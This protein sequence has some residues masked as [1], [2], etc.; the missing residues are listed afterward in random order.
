MAKFCIFCGTQL[1]DNAVFC[2][3]CGKRV[4]PETTPEG[5][6]VI[7]APP[8]AVVTISDEP[9]AIREEPNAAPRQ[10]KKAAPAPAAEENEQI[11]PLVIPAPPGAAV[12]ISDE[13]PVMPDGPKAAPKRR[14]KAA[15]VPA[16]EE[17][18]Q[19]EP[20]VIPAP[21][22]A[23]VTI[24]DE[25]PKALQKP[26]PASRRKEKSSSSTKSKN[27]GCFVNLILIFVMVAEL[28]VA[29]FKYPGFLKTEEKDRV[30]YMKTPVPTRIVN[31]ASTAVPAIT[32][33]DDMDPVY[34]P[35]QIA[36]APTIS[37]PVSGDN[38][39]AEAG[40]V[41]V[42][43]RSWNL[44]NDSDM[45]T[46]KDLPVISG[47]DS[48]KIIKGYEFSLASGQ[49]EFATH[50][51]ITI[52]RTDS[53]SPGTCVWFNDKTGEWEPVYCRVSE[54]GKSY[55][56]RTNHFSLFGEY[57]FDPE[58]LKLVPLEEGSEIA[59]FLDGDEN[60]FY[61]RSSSKKDIRHWKVAID[62]ERMWNL[63]KGKGEED[64][65]QLRAR[66]NQLLSR[67][68]Q[69]GGQP[70]WDPSLM[71]NAGNLQ[72]TSGNLGTEWSFFGLAA[73]GSKL[74]WW[75]FM[76][77]L[78]GPQMLG[79]DVALTTIK[80]V[81]EINLRKMNGEDFLSRISA[82]LWTN[83][84]SLT[85][86]AVSIAALWTGGIPGCI[87]AAAWGGIN[88]TY[89]YVVS[90]YVQNRTWSDVVKDPTLRESYFSYYFNPDSSVY[91]DESKKYELIGDE[92]YEVK[93]LFEE[94]G[95]EFR[96]FV[97]GK[98]PEQ[99]GNSRGS[100]SGSY[101]TRLYD[102]VME[103]PKDMTEEDREALKKVFEEEGGLFVH[104]D[105]ITNAPGVWAD[106][107]TYSK[108]WP[109]IL[110]TILTV[111][112]D[113]SPEYSRKVLDEFYENF[114][115]AYWNMT[116]AQREIM[117]NI[118]GPKT[119][120]DLSSS[121]ERDELRKEFARLL[122]SE[123][124]PMLDEAAESI[125]IEAYQKV[126]DETEHKLLPVLNTEL[127]FHVKDQSL[128][129]GEDFSKSRYNVNWETIKE[130]SPYKNGDKLFSDPGFRTPMRFSLPAEGPLFLP[131]GDTDQ[132][133]SKH[134]YYP[135]D[136]NF[137]PKPMGGDVV[138][139]CSVYHYLMMGAPEKII[140]TDPFAKD[141]EKAPRVEGAFTIPDIPAPAL[142][143]KTGKYES[144][145]KVDVNVVIPIE[146]NKYEDSGRYDIYGYVRAD[147][148]PLVDDFNFR[149]DKIC[150]SASAVIKPDGSI[151][152]TGNGGAEVD[153][154]T[155]KGNMTA[156]FTMEGKINPSDK[157]G[158]C[159][160]SGSGTI[161]LVN[162]VS[163]AMN[164]SGTKSGTITFSGEG[165]LRS[166]KLTDGSSPAPF[167]E[168]KSLYCI[169]EGPVSVKGNWTR[170][171]EQ[172]GV[173]DKTGTGKLGITIKMR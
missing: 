158:T 167:N 15:P 3:Q 142:N 42:D 36:S 4:Q 8:E 11:E 46:V 132:K 24:S 150:E 154:G 47:S 92:Y 111:C 63:Y 126:L 9:P 156:S 59:A 62:Y 51:T 75:P 87:I 20:L 21:P 105:L 137:I 37:V 82:S 64:I 163:D 120:Y 29:G 84:R 50:V 16:A 86:I 162:P 98:E 106:Q 144:V 10:W 14:K 104:A 127:V 149:Y 100:W 152:V 65:N 121:A 79:I 69:S 151:H 53:N 131:Y 81:E 1:P 161:E 109:K 168:W 70:D 101:F 93:S 89:D 128:Q 122:Q 145:K 49:T 56:I 28:V 61:L 134:E 94:R 43:L 114:A 78:I 139:R 97:F 103:F 165:V 115:D 148:F 157:E 68:S 45:L 112:E 125:R 108:G 83:S 38:P 153:R 116:T 140:F 33:E 31:A 135:Y 22:G 52:P 91:I 66:V 44:D 173:Y 72:N 77:Q 129:P 40:A 117:E 41:K 2:S 80:V 12:T 170:G 32:D 67:G 110:K 5:R 123:T 54:D 169:M 88:I 17:N 30:Y 26:K 171:P 35:A 136:D 27:S 34:T 118:T 133:V 48:G 85:G 6:L 60:I 23:A 13:P 155:Y 124:Q 19:I 39:V 164:L 76:D 73:S 138:F 102:T 55:N 95:L 172:S 166:Y 119:R 74:K 147:G 96:R 71:N 18:E 25:P 99:S 159:K 160:I 141:Y 113:D 57:W 7:P 130:N 58:L 90:R 107:R 143:S 146:E